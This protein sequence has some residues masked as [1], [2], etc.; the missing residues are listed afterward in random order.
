M[1]LGRCRDCERHLST[2]AF[3]CR[4]CGAEGHPAKSEASPFGFVVLIGGGVVVLAAIGGPLNGGN[5]YGGGGGGGGNY[6]AAAPAL[7]APVTPVAPAQQCYWRWDR[8]YAGRIFSHRE[9]GA[10]YFV[11]PGIVRHPYRDV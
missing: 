7:T 10:P 1:A 2:D 4:Y 9:F 6:S 11:G 8:R 3:R 5:N